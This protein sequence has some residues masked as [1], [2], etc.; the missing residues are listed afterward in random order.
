MARYIVI[1]P[2]CLLFLIQST[3]LAHAAEPL[4]TAQSYILLDAKANQIIMEHQAHELRPP[5]STTKIMTAILALELGNLWQQVE[6]SKKAATVGEATINLEPGEKIALNN[7]IKGA[8][9]KSGNDATIA[10]AEHLAGSEELFVFL[11]NRKAKML[12]AKHTSFQN[13]NGL[14]K[15]GHYSTAYD[16]ALMAR[17]G[18]NKKMFEGIVS[19]KETAIPWE[20]KTW[21]RFLKNTNKL[22]WKYPGA[23]GVKTGTTKEAGNCLVAS[24]QRNDRLLIAVVLNS[25][26]RFG[27]ATKLLNYGFDNSVLRKIPRGSEFGALY[28]AQGEMNRI[29]LVTAAD[30]YYLQK[31]GDNIERKIITAKCRF[32]Y[33]NKGTPVGYLI[34]LSN[35]REMG[36][37]PLVTDEKSGHER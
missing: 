32:D 31:P 24:A 11:M 29:P 30:F 13:P 33:L 25:Q 22:L 17:Y 18:M 2:L 37:V 27:D 15:K 9:I 1:V 3:F 6:V 34:L 19:T 7:L 28:A 10:I 20:G 36:R 8:L 21:N 12:G 23:N 26:D 14:P 4:I 35:G 16:L 5:A